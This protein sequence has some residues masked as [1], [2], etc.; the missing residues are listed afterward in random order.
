MDQTTE[1]TWQALHLRAARGERLTS[2]E[3]AFYEAGL[4]QR[5]QDEILNDNVILLRQARARIAEMEA[6]QEQLQARHDELEA[7]IA[8]LEGSLS[9]R[10]RHLL[11]V[12]N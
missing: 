1:Q 11:D 12:E 6:E 2:E 7:E 9:G 10:T 8:T 3:R 5:H 4:S